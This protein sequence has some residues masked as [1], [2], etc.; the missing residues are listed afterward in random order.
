MVAS[1]LLLACLL[2]GCGFVPAADVTA[3]E[4]VSLWPFVDMIVTW[5][6]DSAQED[7]P[8]QEGHYQG[9]FAPGAA[10]SLSA[11]NHSW[12]QPHASWPSH[13]FPISYGWN[14][15]V[16]SSKQVGGQYDFWLNSSGVSEMTEALEGP[17]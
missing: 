14:A 15:D 6:G 11:E 13:L 1:L 4:E 7:K 9:L 8:P 17:T 3:T 2:Q 5:G 16:P 10:A 12:W